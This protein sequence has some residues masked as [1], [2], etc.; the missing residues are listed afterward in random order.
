M[1][2]KYIALIETYVHVIVP[3]QDQCTMYNVG[4]HFF[5]QAADFKG[6]IKS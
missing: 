5:D 6:E 2:G 3:L 4:R 1:Y